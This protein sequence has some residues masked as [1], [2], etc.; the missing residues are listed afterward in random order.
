MHSNHSEIPFKAHYISA[1]FLLAFENSTECGLHTRSPIFCILSI[2]HKHR[3]S[4]T[5]GN[6][7]PQTVQTSHR[8]QKYFLPTNKFNSWWELITT[9][10]TPPIR[11][12]MHVHTLN[13]LLLSNYSNRRPGDIY[14]T[15]VLSD[16]YRFHVNPSSIASESCFICILTQLL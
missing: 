6:N 12:T 11:P 5:C 1:Q 13:C 14:P 10:D 3:P 4:L 15:L 16:W 8:L 7:V 2:V 9:S